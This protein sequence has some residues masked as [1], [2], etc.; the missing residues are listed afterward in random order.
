[1]AAILF[2]MEH[3]WKTKQKATIGILNVLGIT[4]P[5]VCHGKVPKL[6]RGY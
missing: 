1:M 4:A 5:N 6:V 3:H 2:K